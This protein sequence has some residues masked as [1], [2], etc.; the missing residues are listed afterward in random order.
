MHQKEIIFTKPFQGPKKVI[1]I[2]VF[3]LLTMTFCG[4]IL[5][6]ICTFRFISRRTLRD[7]V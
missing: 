6:I 4:L 5:S 3:F 1:C 2:T 7:I